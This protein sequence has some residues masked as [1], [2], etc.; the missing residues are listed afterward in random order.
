MHIE[1]TLMKLNICLFLVKDDGLIEKYNEIWEKVKN[2]IKKEF[3]SE[4]VYNEKY[5]NTEIK[6]CN[7][8]INTNF[9]NNKIPQECSQ[10]ICLSVI[11][12]QVK[13]IILKCFKKNVN[14]LLKKKKCQSIL[15]LTY[16]FFLILV[17]KILMKKILMKKIEESSNEKN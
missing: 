5:L 7:G 9:H 17:E 6:S 8:K 2:S 1:E 11:L 4:P 13:I 16:T 10:F 15:L 14:I 12:E 3:D